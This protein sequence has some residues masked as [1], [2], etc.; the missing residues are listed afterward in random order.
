VSTL[1]SK[2]DE[3]QF[4]QDDQVLFLRHAIKRFRRFSSCA[5]SNSQT[6]SINGP[7]C[8]IRQAT[9]ANATAKWVFPYGK[10]H[11]AAA[12][13]QELVQTEWQRPFHSLHTVISCALNEICFSKM[14]SAT[15]MTSVTSNNP[16]WNGSSLHP[17]RGA[18]RTTAVYHHFKFG[19]FLMEPDFQRFHDN[20]CYKFD[21]VVCDS[22]IVWIRK[23]DHKLLRPR[24]CSNIYKKNPV[25]SVYLGFCR[26]PS[27]MAQHTYQVFSP[28]GHFSLSRGDV[29]VNDDL[30]VRSG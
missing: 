28:N 26:T 4:I 30:A 15:S 11:F 24:S 9:K 7:C 8:P 6:L 2:R 13:G 17:V 29:L 20:G 5:R 16:Q 10:T 18:L 21:R 25:Y 23:G 22:I 27:I 1:G 14:N 19:L 3:T 12:V